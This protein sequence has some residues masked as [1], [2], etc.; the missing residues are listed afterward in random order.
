MNFKIP[1]IN[2]DKGLDLYDYDEDLYLIVLRSYAENNPEVLDRLRSVSID[3]LEDY[4]SNVHGIR[5]T[6]VAIGAEDL[7]KA[8]SRME[9]LA[10][11]GDLAKLLLENEAFLK[12]ADTLIADVKAWLALIN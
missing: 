3:T 1:G 4:L 2:T 6:S 5:G 10:K 11:A 12:Q 9:A 8:A 7:G